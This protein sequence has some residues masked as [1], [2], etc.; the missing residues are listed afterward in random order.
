VNLAL[1]LVTAVVAQAGT[2]P[3]APAYAQNEI[4]VKF[5]ETVAA[6]GGLQIRMVVPRR[7]GD[8]IP[9]LTPENFTARLEVRNTGDQP[10]RLAEQNNT[11]G[12]EYVI[13]EWL[14][15]L[16]LDVR[17]PDRAGCG[18]FRAY[19]G[20][21]D[22]YWYR[23]GSEPS[24]REIKPGET[25]GFNVRLRGLADLE[26]TN[27]LSLRGHCGLRPGLYIT[28][29]KSGLWHGHAVGAYVPVIIRANAPA[30]D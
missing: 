25:A 10:V 24:V 15:G 3:P 2:R 23:I 22:G 16:Y 5:R 8:Q 20:Q 27:L 18:F 29:N 26:G 28:D 9:I 7:D 4:I 21:I 19:D 1:T 12:D 30:D 6:A 11:S 14:I 17:A 13:D